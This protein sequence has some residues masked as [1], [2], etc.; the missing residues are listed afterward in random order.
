MQ[1]I[2]LLFVL[3]CALAFA[4]EVQPEEQAVVNPEEAVQEVK[5][6][7]DVNPIPAEEPVAAVNAA[8]IAEPE[9]EKEPEG[10]APVNTAADADA[11]EVQRLISTL[12]GKYV[13]LSAKL[14]AMEAKSAAKAEASKIEDAN[15]EDDAADAEKNANVNPAVAAAAAELKAAKR[16]AKAEAKKQKITDE[17]GRIAEQLTFLKVELSPLLE[18]AS[19]KLQQKQRR[20]ALKAAWKQAQADCEAQN[21]KVI[22]EGPIDKIDREISF[23]QCKRAILVEKAKE[24]DESN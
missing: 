12:S 13:K 10:D 22:G 2:V 1:F 8:D 6:E 4:A 18:E 21:V 19:N 9:K 3:L 20:S 24:Y 15:I 5:N 23:L 7:I 14:A 11:E 17:L 16:A